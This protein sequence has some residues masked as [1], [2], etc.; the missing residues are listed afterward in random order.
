MVLQVKSQDAVPTLVSQFVYISEIFKSYQMIW[1]YRLS[2][3]AVPTLGSQCVYISEIFKSY[4]MIWLYRL[5]HRMLCTHWDPSVCTSVKY[6][7][8]IK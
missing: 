1:L 4:Q 5:S 6:L 3:D 7:S 8:H 2:L